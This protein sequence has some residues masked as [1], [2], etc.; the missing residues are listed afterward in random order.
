MIIYIFKFVLNQ[1]SF[2]AVVS[3]LTPVKD[4]QTTMQCTVDDNYIL[5]PTAVCKYD[6]N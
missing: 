5:E 2:T 4:L 1:R 3:L 6:L